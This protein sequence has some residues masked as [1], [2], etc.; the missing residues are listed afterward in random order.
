MLRAGSFPASE[1]GTS[2]ALSA[3][4]LR[5]EAGTRACQCRGLNLAQPG[6]L[7]PPPGGVAAS[8]PAGDSGRDRRVPF[9]AA[10]SIKALSA[11]QVAESERKVAGRR[12]ARAVR[13][14]A[15]VK[16]ADAPA[17]AETRGALARLPSRWPHHDRRLGWP[18]APALARDPATLRLVALRPHAPGRATFMRVPQAQRTA[19]G[20]SPMVRVRQ[21][22]RSS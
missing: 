2:S 17:T 3:D 21:V 5:G 22:M 11:G 15:C 14:S 7:T 13:T 19:H 18:A 16:V 4:A 12:A 9:R 8:T 20:G 6:A 10:Q 1:A